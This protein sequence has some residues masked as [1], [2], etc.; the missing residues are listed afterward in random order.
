MRTGLIDN[1]IGNPADIGPMY[2][3]VDFEVPLFL[4]CFVLWV[5]YTVWQMKFEYAHFVKEEKELRKS[6][7]K[8]LLEANSKSVVK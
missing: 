7:L 2:P 6:G 1:W 8:A 5:L 4:V 3:L